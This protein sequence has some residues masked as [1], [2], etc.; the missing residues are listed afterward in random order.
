MCSGCSGDYDGDFEDCDES[1]GDSSEGDPPAWICGEPEEA[2]TGLSAGNA[3]SFEAE[4]DAEANSQSASLQRA[5]GE[6]AGEI[7]EIRVS[8]TQIVEMRVIKAKCR[9][10]K[11]LRGTEAA[12]THA[13]RKE[14]RVASAKYYQTRGAGSENL[15]DHVQVPCTRGIA[16]AAAGEFRRWVR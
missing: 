4:W 8:A 12:E 14:R 2:R 1:P 3:G 7:C 10:I 15:S 5:R 16:A 6:S 13:A 9:E 11:E